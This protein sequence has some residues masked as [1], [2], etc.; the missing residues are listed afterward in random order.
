[1]LLEA[2]AAI[3][4]GIETLLETAGIRADEVCT[5]YLAGGFGMHLNV[6]HEIA[7]GLLPGFRPEQ[8]RQCRVDLACEMLLHSEDPLAIIAVR[9]GFCDQSYFTRVFRDVKGLTPGQFREQRPR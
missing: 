5:V 9:C 4:A 7:V 1:M 8:I 2:K 3:G 6:P